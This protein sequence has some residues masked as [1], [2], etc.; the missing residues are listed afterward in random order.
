[1]LEIAATLMGLK[2]TL[3]R[4]CEFKNQEAVRTYELQ[5]LK[6]RQ[7]FLQVST[8]SRR[9]LSKPSVCLILSVHSV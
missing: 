2:L 5:V 7:S 8:P 9:V 4:C 1:M 3:R 6:V